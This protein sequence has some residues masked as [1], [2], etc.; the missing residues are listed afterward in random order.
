MNARRGFFRIWIVLAAVFVVAVAISAFEPISKAF[1]ST[2]FLPVSCTE[3]RGS[4]GVDYAYS[5][6]E[7]GPWDS[8]ISTTIDTC[9]YSLETI[10]KLYPE[11]A[12]LSNRALKEGLLKKGG[13]S[14]PEPWLV[15]GVFALIAVLPP[16]VLL[17]LGAAVGWALIGF[18]KSPDVAP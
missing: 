13:I 11:Y 2:Q 7:P 6:R 4:P 1:T 9:W 17:L 18:R 3:A 10:R 15:L 16:I 8:F 14:P 5:P 12:E